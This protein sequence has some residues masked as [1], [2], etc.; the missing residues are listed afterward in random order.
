MKAQVG[1]V[2]TSVLDVNARDTVSPLF[3][4]RPPAL[5]ESVTA[6]SSGWVL[7]IVAEPE[8]DVTSVPALPTV[9]PKAIV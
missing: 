1:A 4:S 3:T 6:A 7:S 5:S 9:S 2:V 8:P